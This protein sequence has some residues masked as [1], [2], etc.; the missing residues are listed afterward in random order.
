M[1]MGSSPSYRRFGRQSSGIRRRFIMRA[2]RDTAGAAAIEFGIIVPVLTLMVIAV[3]DLGT[4]IYRRMQV[5]DAA[6]AAAQYAIR[7]GFD[8]TAISNAVASATNNSAITASPAPL[9]FCG[10]ASATSISTVSCGTTCPSGAKA[11]T[12]A[13]VSAQVT[14]N[15]TLNYG[16]APR[17]YTFNAQSTVRLQ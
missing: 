4:G 10:C 15:T 2:A 11:G 7:N 1:T 9:Q 16:V 14:Y 17:S 3:T 13:T 6:Q 12:Y 5:E 8:A